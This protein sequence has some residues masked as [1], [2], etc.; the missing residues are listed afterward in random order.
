[1]IPLGKNWKG[2]LEPADAGGYVVL[3]CGALENARILLNS[4]RQIM[5]RQ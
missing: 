4:N 1:M 3:C 5:H 2:L